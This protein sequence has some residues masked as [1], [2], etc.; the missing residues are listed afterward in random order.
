MDALYKHSR[1]VKGGVLGLVLGLII[2]FGVSWFVFRISGREAM[3]MRWL[4]SDSKDRGYLTY[5]EY[6]QKKVREKT[7][8]AWK[9]RIKSLLPK[10][11]T[12]NNQ[13]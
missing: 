9:L 4:G 7:V 13:Q 1:E 11:D 3:L 10:N 5:E 8:E 2:L 6:K 12:R